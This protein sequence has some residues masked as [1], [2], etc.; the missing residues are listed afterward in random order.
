M[1]LRKLHN[2]QSCTVSPFK[3]VFLHTPSVCN[4][5]SV[6]ISCLTFIISHSTG[7]GQTHP[8]MYPASSYYTGVPQHG[9]P[10]MSPQNTP[11]GKAPPTSTNYSTNYYPNS[12]PQ[13]GAPP[14]TGSAF[15]SA[16]PAQIPVSSNPVASVA[17]QFP[18]HSYSQHYAMSANYYG[19]N[20]SPTAQGQQNPPSASS[21]AN[22][23]PPLYP[24][25]SYPSAPGSSQFGTLRSSQA[26]GGAPP[27]QSAL[28]SQQQ[29]SQG[30]RATPT[31]P[32]Q[33]GYGAPPLQQTAAINGQSNAGRWDSRPEHMKDCTVVS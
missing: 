25:V 12:H 5:P 32:A 23:G 7:P 28:Q 6:L 20:Y 24:I 27:T 30:S 19:Q 9:Y 1:L 15:Y 16:P 14:S 8:A 22:L 10:T 18:P 4:G 17:P 13:A 2:G 11:P 31:P 29:Y 21:S 3:N 26:V 33:Q